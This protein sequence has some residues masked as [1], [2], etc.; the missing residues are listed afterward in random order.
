MIGDDVGAC[1]AQ[2]KPNLA[3]YLGGMGAR[4]KN[5]HNEMAVRYGYGEAAAT[6]QDL[7]LSGRKQEAA[8]AVPDD[9]CDEL[10]LCGPVAR[11]RDRYRAW[12]DAGVTT[13]LVQSRQP[14]ALE[15]MADVARE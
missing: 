2:M 3:L 7:Y 10:S 8:E 12:A 9:L 14:E 15:L 6:I 1:L 11:I 4:E 5:F 13:M